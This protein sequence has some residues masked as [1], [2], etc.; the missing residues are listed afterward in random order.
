[1]KEK[2]GVTPELHALAKQFNENLYNAMTNET[3]TD[4]LISQVAAFKDI[5]D[6]VGPGLMTPEE[7]AHI[8]EKSVSMVEK[9]LERIEENNKTQKEEPEDE[10]DE[11]DAED[12]ALLKEE[13]S[14]EHDLQLA[15]AE[16][17]GVLFKTHKE[18]VAPLVEK[19]RNEVL[20]AAFTSGEQKRLKFAIFILDDMV[21][22]LG[23]AYF[24]A[25]DFSSIVQTICQFSGS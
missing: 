15:A 12:L 18:S 11:L 9:S 5:I 4:T 17:M 1:M 13:N 2:T 14:N 24:S 21:E 22:H 3:E 7:V 23:P 25:E 20:V 8:G 16:L 6:E 19:L 10:D